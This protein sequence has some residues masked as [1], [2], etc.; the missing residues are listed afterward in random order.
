LITLKIANATGI[1]YVT[2]AIDIDVANELMSSFED[3]Y[4]ILQTSLNKLIH[5]ADDAELINTTFRSMH[6]I[7]GN[8]SMMQ[9]TP[10]VDYAHEVEEAISAMRS[11]YFS[12]T[13]TLCDLLLTSVDRLRDLHKKYLFNKEIA[14]INEVEIAKT[15]GAMA[16][17]RTAEEVE[18]LCKEL[19]VLFAPDQTTD[20]SSD[21][22]EDLKKDSGNSLTIENVSQH[23]DYLTLTE[24]Q[25]E[26]LVL[27]RLLSLQVDEQ[28]DFWHQ[29]T[30]LLLYLSLRAAE[31][32]DKNLDKIQLVAAVYM[33]DAGMAF[34]PDNIVNKNN[35]LNAMETK[36]LQQHPVWGYNLVKRMT[37]WE[38]A[39]QMILEHHEHIDG[40]GYPYQKKGDELSEGAKLLAIVDAYYAM[41]NL[42]AD[43]SH[44]RSIMRA[45]SEIN[46]CID[47]QF[48]SYWVSMFNEVIRAEVK[49]GNI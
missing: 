31:L 16:N 11:G 44:R 48:C 29:R 13:P 45:I 36:K 47:T 42:R 27:F 17:A 18:S 40:E 28:N 1:N 22:T 9:V 10:L 41:T 35:K 19:I 37:G 25:Q 6:T 39:A 12:P 32:S 7:K 30:D 33:H 2:I 34:V 5:N 4:E 21:P 46:A 14:P 24:Q 23:T 8:A 38:E 43:R 20:D 49:A 26:D 15:F 3:H